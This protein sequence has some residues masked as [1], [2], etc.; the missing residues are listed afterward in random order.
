MSYCFWNIGIVIPES[1]S[2][3]TKLNLLVCEKAT[4]QGYL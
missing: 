2:N 4:F 1:V 3:L